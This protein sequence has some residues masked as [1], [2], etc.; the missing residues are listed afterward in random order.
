MTA[1][2][3]ELTRKKLQR[4]RVYTGCGYAILASI[5]MI[6]IHKLLHVDYSIGSLDPT[7]CFESTA[8]L[9]F[10]F[11]WLIKGETFL[12]DEGSYTVVTADGSI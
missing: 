6:G 11:A 8:L 4:N 10:G 12:K 1:D 5:L 3:K 7:F 2:N 9:A